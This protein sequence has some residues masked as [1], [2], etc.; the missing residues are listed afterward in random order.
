MLQRIGY[1]TVRIKSNISNTR[2]RKSHTHTHTH[3]A[4]VCTKQIVC[5]FVSLY[6]FVLQA[7]IIVLQP[8]NR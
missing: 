4:T 6:F 5:F 1:S 7:F 2:Y 3:T 8:L